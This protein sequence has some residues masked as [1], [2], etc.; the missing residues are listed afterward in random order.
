MTDASML[1]AIDALHERG[2]PAAMVTVVATDGSSYR[3]AGARMVVGPSGSS[4]GMVSGGC[5]ESDIERIA[6]VVLEEGTARRVVFD[7]ADDDEALLGW[8]LGCGG[9]ITVLVQPVPPTSVPVLALRTA[10]R[11]RA[12]VKLVTLVDPGG[13]PLD[14]GAALLVGE[15]G[16]VQGSLG[17][18]AADAAAALLP[19]GPLPAVRR[20]GL[21]PH[22]VDVLVEALRPPIRLLLCGAGDDAVPLAGCA[23]GM[24]WGVVVADH[25]PAALEPA[26]FPSAEALVH[27][28]D[29]A[30]VGVW[31]DESTHAVVMSHNLERD[32]GYLRA[33]LSTPVPYIGVLGPRRRLQRLLDGGPPRSPQDEARLHGPVGLDIGA[34]GPE[35]VAVAITA[36]IVARARRHPGGF[37]RDR[38]GAIHQPPAP[39][40]LPT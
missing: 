39:E 21:A 13:A 29:P 14:P 9:V 38:Q 26:R 6:R 8:G 1:A 32:G 25:R 10:V 7:L 3:R 37:L 11:G 15:G 40:V 31:C 22:P 18:R 33:L 28:R 36:E 12:P 30:S 35:E 17:D 4:T 23:A 19:A 20:L 5:L 24:G 34:D 27:V 16:A 2:E